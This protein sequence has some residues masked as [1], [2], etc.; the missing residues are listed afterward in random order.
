M[1]DEE[2]VSLEVLA[3]VY[4]KMYLK[5]QEIQK[6]LDKIEEQK[7]EVKNA[8]KDQ[9]REMGVTSVKTEGGSITLS[10]KRRYYTD[11]WDSFKTFMMDN[12]ALDLVEKE[13][14]NQTW[15]YL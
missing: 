6:Q 12:D 10:T 14:H 4:R 3:K 15:L 2:V 13:S 1:S 8:M 7:E 5:G 9:M 11:D